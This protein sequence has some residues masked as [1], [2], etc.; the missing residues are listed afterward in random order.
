M[1]ATRALLPPVWTGPI[2]S[3]HIE[4]LLD[5]REPR[6][7]VDVKVGIPKYRTK[8]TTKRTMMTYSVNPSH[9]FTKDQRMLKKVVL[10]N[11]VSVK[12]PF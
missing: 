1:S 7:P 3:Q 11:L 2:S 10:S 9:L 8:L 6:V 12:V 5:M 4:A